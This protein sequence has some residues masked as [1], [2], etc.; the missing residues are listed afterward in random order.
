[1]RRALNIAILCSFLFAFTFALVLGLAGKADAGN[2]PCCLNPC[3]PPM[4]GPGTW[5]YWID[6][7]EE[8]F[9]HGDTIGPPGQYGCVVF[10]DP[11]GC[12]L[13]LGGCAQP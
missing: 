6:A 3:V 4:T 11:R 10:E 13:I 12:Y 5:G 9:I 8:G 7:P 1:M 2:S